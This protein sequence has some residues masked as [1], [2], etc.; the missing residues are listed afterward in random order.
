[1]TD[2]DA[3]D[4]T[5]GTAIKKGLCSAINWLALVATALGL[6]LKNYWAIPW[7]IVLL[8]VNAA[9][10][11]LRNM[12]AAYEN[13][14]RAHDARAQQLLEEIRKLRRFTE[15]QEEVAKMMLAKCSPGG[16][17][18]LWCLLHYGPINATYQSPHPGN[19]HSGSIGELHTL[20]FIG[21]THPPTPRLVAPES[22]WV[23]KAEFKDVLEY[24]VPKPESTGAPA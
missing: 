1:M 9:Y 11:A 2:Y 8:T 21:Q 22:F 15:E 20:G 3:P 23:I 17:A 14:E 6:S 16:C 4:V 24:L 5:L 7:A 12:Q 18:L 10:K 13:R 19:L